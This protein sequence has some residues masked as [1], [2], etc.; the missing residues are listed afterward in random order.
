MSG[1]VIYM[2]PGSP[3][4]RAVAVA[5]EEK[6]VP[7]RVAGLRPPELRGPEY[8]ARQ[9]FGKMPAFQHGD[10]ALY[11]TQA[12]LRYLDRVLPAPPLSPTHTRTLARMDQLMNISDN[13]LFRGVGSVIGFERVVGPKIIGSTPDET[14]IAAAIPD[15]HRVFAE[16]SHLLGGQTYFTGELLSLADVMIAPQMDM[17]AGT[18]EWEILTASRGNLAGWMTRMNARPSMQATQWEKVAT[19]ATA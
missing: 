8:L 13:Y 15:A 17:L 6:A 7:Y 12:I 3:Y 1:F 5:L 2:V 18:P 11:E 16:L 10:F 4:G 9:P 14:R 19:M